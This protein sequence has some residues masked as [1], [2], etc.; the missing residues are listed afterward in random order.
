MQQNSA[1][2]LET[3]KLAT[4]STVRAIAG[5]DE[6]EVHFGLIPRLSSG[7]V[8][9]PLPTPGCS[10]T[11][12]NAIRGIADEYALR[13][14]YHK[15]AQ[16][17]KFMPSPNSMAAEIFSKA[18][19]AR[20]CSIGANLMAGVANNLDAKL[21]AD[22]TQYGYHKKAKDPLTIPLTVSLLIRERL[23]GRRLPPAA[24][25]TAE[26]WRQFIEDKAGEAL[27]G[28]QQVSTHDQ[29]AYAQACLALIESLGFGNEISPSPDTTDEQGEDESAGTGEVGEDGQEP[30]QMEADTGTMEEG[31]EEGAEM[32]MDMDGPDG[33]ITQDAEGSPQGGI[34]EQGRIQPAPFYQAYTTK[35]D[36]IVSAASLCK[37]AELSRLYDLLSQKLQAVSQSTAA[38]ANRLQRQLMAKQNRSW[39]F[40]QDEGILDTSRLAGIIANPNNSLVFKQELETKFRDTVV[41]MLIDSSG[42]MRG[43]SMTMAAMCADMLARTLERCSVKVEILGFTTRAWRGGQSRELWLADGKP[44]QPGRLNDLR[45]LIYKSA[46]E[47]WRK[48]RRNLG[49]M[50]REELLKENIDGEALIWAHNRLVGCKENRKILMV[51][52]DGLPVDNSTLLVNPSNCLEQHLK[53]AIELIEKASCVELV[54]IGIG[55]DVTHHYERAVT[56]TDPEQLAGAMTDQLAALFET[57]D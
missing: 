44:K 7:K 56:L 27:D 10:E 50:M 24:E 20:I 4:T 6:L 16:T 18:E 11:E 34:D 13:R 36:E 2:L 25:R 1:D 38:L 32:S 28:L 52:S 46:D 55:H 31:A 54:A 8:C 29:T 26:H 33:D 57:K 12:L 19:T 53:Y 49:L 43:R 5:D 40:D 37:P 41:T 15:P 17:R 39:I 42:S 47:N 3:F 21:D 45:H 48:A 9:L 51:I 30:L 35:F 23:T 14:R 22:C